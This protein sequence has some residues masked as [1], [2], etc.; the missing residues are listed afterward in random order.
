MEDKESK[1]NLKII[2]EAEAERGQEKELEKEVE[3]EGEKKEQIFDLQLGDIIQLNAPS[4]IDLHDKQF[5]I[6]FINNNKIELINEKKTITLEIT[7][8]GNF[9]EESIENIIILYRN[10][11]PSY[12]VQNNL[13]LYSNISIYFGEPLPKILNGKITNVEEDMIE[14]KLFPSNDVI[15]I[16]F[17]YSGIPENLNIE[18]IV[19][20]DKSIDD[21]VEKQEV[22]EKQKQEKEDD[23]FSAYLDLDNREHLDTDLLFNEDN[24]KL[25]E[26]LDDIIDFD[27][28]E[29]EIFH[30]VNVS[31]EEKRYSL[32]EQISDYMDYRLDEYKKKE[33]NNLLKNNIHHEVTRYTELRK[34]YSDFDENNNANKPVLKN[35]YF[36]PLKELLINLNKKIYWLLPVTNNKKIFVEN[37]E[38]LGDIDEDLIIMK[39]SEFLERLIDLT[40]KWSAKSSNKT[41]NNYKKF[42]SDLYSVYESSISNYDSDS[43]NLDVN[44]QLNV[45]NDLYNNFYSYVLKSEKNSNPEIIEERFVMDVFTNGLKMFEMDIVNSKKIFKPKELTINDKIS[46]ISFLTLPLP[47]FNFSKINMEYTSLYSKSNLSTNFLNYSHLLNTYT[48]VNNFTMDNNMKPRFIDSHTNIHDDTIFDSINS[49]NN[50]TLLDAD[51]KEEKFDYL[52]ESFIPTKLKTLAKIFEN[53][54]IHNFTELVNIVQ[55]ANIDMYNLHFNDYKLIKSFFDKNLK[56]YKEEYLSNRDLISKILSSYNYENQVKKDNYYGFNLLNK[57]LKQEVFEQYSIQEEYTSI[58]ELYNKFLKIDNSKF[59]LNALNKNIMDLIVSNLLENFI[60]QSKDLDVN[61]KDLTETDRDDCEKYYLSKKYN[62]IAEL[63]EDNNKLIYFDTIYDKTFYSIINDFENEKE[64]MGTKQFFEFLTGKIIEVM[65]YSK[66]NALREAK[67]I[68]EEKKEIIDDDYALLIDKESKKNYIYIRKNNI[69]ELDE[70]FKN[71]F[72]IDSNKIFCDSSKECI[73][74]GEKCLSGDKISNDVK[75][76]VDKILENFEYKYNL[77]IEEIKGKINDSFENSK[78]YIKK[79]KIINNYNEKTNKLLLEYDKEFDSNVVRS[80]H[81]DLRDYVLSIKDFSKKQEYIR[82]FCLKFTRNPIKDEETN[83]LYCNK[84]SV[85][86]IPKFLLRLAN[87]FVTSENYNIVLDTICAEQGTISDDNNYWVDKYSGYIIKSIEFSSDEGFDEQGFKLNTKELMES[88]YNIDLNKDNPKLANPDVNTINSI[89]NSVTQQIGINLT[90]HYEFIINSIIKIQSVSVLSREQY[91]KMLKAHSKKGEKTK[92]LPIYEDVYNLSLLLL[93]LIFIVI[94]IQVNI[95]N[96]KT[97]KTFPGC[98]KS[99]NGYPFDGSENKT[100][101][102]YIACVASKMKSS[103]KP[104]NSILK[105]N[106]STIIKKMDALIEKFIINNPKIGELIQKKQEYLKKEN[107]KQ[108]QDKGQGEVEREDYFFGDYSLESWNTFMPPLKRIIV[109]AETITPLDSTFKDEILENITK[110]KNNNYLDIIEAKNIYLSNAIIDS[111]QKIVSKEAI[112]LES[113]TG[114]PFLENSCCNTT[115][116]AINYFAKLDKSIFE[117]NNLVKNNNILLTKLNELKNAKILYDSNSNRLESTKLKNDF[118]EEIIYKSFMFYCNFENDLPID[119]ELKTIC[120]NKPSPYDYKLTLAEKIDLFKNQ[121]KIYSKSNLNDLLD[122]INKRNIKYIGN[123]GDIINNVEKLRLIIENYENLDEKYLIDDQLLNKFKNVVENYG[124]IDNNSQEIRSLK[125]YFLTSSSVM[126]EN[127]LH[128]ARS[129]QNLGR[130]QY[131]NLTGL[132]DL[133]IVDKNNYLFFREYIKNF[134]ITFPNILIN[135]NINFMNP[136]KHWD[137]S[138]LHKTD[139]YSILKKYYDNLHN[140]EKSEEFSILH[141][142]VF[143]KCKILLEFIEYILYYESNFYNEEVI[144]YSIFD[145]ELVEYFLIYSFYSIIYEYLNNIQSDLFK[146]QVSIIDNYDANIVN[147]NVINYVIDTLTIMNNHFNLLNS[148]Y[149]KIKEKVLFSKEKEKDLITDY[150]KNLSDEERDLENIFKNNKLEKWSKGLQKGI[151]Q[152]VKENY[153]DERD[154]ME[155]QALKEKML[156]K[157]SIVTDMNKEIYNMNKDIYMMDIE[158]EMANDAL[159][160]EE[161]YDMG[162]IPDDDDADSDYEYD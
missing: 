78:K 143:D 23:G 63:E 139:F 138:D 19:I 4:N 99:F 131:N 102:T 126:K 159:I 21:E 25:V 103:I 13:T 83:W 24:E 17:G 89:L 130:K 119:E 112:L 12:I 79:I 146:L 109:R 33:Q 92:Q 61:K 36:K 84:T 9:L 72:Y 132:L 162:N 88:D 3:V 10:P 1:S 55:S 80:P 117:N 57:E 22:A 67:A 110:G 54:K 18:K 52:L 142:I 41:I 105:M 56:F 91:E 101:I 28:E 2:A 7:R 69:W 45:I 108:K 86:L 128:I 113:N 148:D 30:S 20:R 157:K 15:Y 154:T 137:L 14:V 98:I 6:K 129:T 118:S 39:E 32:E 90:H 70:K 114:E 68:M 145:K 27:D 16:D 34:H 106:E 77:S 35:E 135:K 155:K 94:A 48:S 87:A 116:N 44:T 133:K 125:N 71:A 58:E 150:L 122:I 152:Y 40:D 123:N 93:T 120:L 81:E 75:K 64:T 156:N 26:D 134:L 136:P 151:T 76:D 51:S 5:F 100:A 141:K 107:Q 158:E 85:K 95:P 96:I 140:I 29:F 62:S 97:K 43:M 149:K 161:E 74:D 37:K 160:D 104:W 31:D 153:D 127:I 73:S 124:Y 111:I 115:T 53:Y 50:D 59:F 49:F 46:C 144:L 11:S 66:K 82:L 47:I 60:K 121:G 42:I 8:E 38:K 65:N 147:T